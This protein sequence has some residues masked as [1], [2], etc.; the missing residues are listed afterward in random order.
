MNDF[1]TDP[2]TCKTFSYGSSW[3]E[4]LRLIRNVSQHWY[5]RPRPM[6]QPQAFSEEGDPHDYF[7]NVLPTLPVVVHRAV[8]SSKWTERSDL[9]KYF[10]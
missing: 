2:L 10:I 3:T 9:Q 1:S 5:D 4:C 8:R 7:L 6:P